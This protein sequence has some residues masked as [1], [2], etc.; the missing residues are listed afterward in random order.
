MASTIE[1]T[2]NNILV[3]INELN[4]IIQ[5]YLTYDLDVKDTSLVVRLATEVDEILSNYEMGSIFILSK[6]HKNKTDVLAKKELYSKYMQYITHENIIDKLNRIYGLCK[7]LRNIYKIVEEEYIQAFDTYEFTPITTNYEEK[8]N[9]V[10]KCGNEYHI[11]SKNSEFVCHEC[12]NTEK[13]FGIVFED[14]QFFFQEGQRTKHGKYDPTKHCKFWV[15]RI[16][17]RE[18]TEIPQIVIDGVK[19]CVKRDDVYLDQLSCPIIRS[20][21][22]E[23]KLTKYNDHVPLIRKT[24]TNNEPEQLTDTETTLVYLH[25]SR[26]IQVYNK[27]KPD[28]KPNCPYHPFFIFK[29]LE[30][31]LKHPLQRLRRKNILSYI[32]LQSRETL[33]ENDRIWEPICTQIPGFTYLPTDGA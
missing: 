10:C 33:I 14:E 13:L 32:H 16:Q 18:N 7:K 11:E 12:G 30:Q 3:K 26:V 21:L 1:T 17:A 25:F 24:I 29:I 22:K 19:R 27:T 8:S 4:T 31:I 20:Y 6:Y 15:D 5:T 2:D 28:N 23:L 9:E